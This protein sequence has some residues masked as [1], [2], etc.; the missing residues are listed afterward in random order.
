CEGLGR[1]YEQIFAKL[2]L[3]VQERFFAALD[4]GCNANTLSRLAAQY[5]RVRGGIGFNK[6][7]AEY[8]AF[9]TDPYSHTPGHAGARQPG[10]TGQVKEEILTRFGELGVRVSDGAAR[11]EPRLLRRQEFL[12]TP[13]K[14]RMLDVNN[15]WQI[16]ETPEHGLAFSLCQVPITYRLDVRSAAD[17]AITIRMSDGRQQQLEGLALPREIS[18]SIFKRDGTIAQLDVA[19]GQQWLM[20]QGAG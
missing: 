2:L 7:P 12:A 8:G 6:S 4:S 20:Q 17:A 11:F 19:F 18:Q 9:P 16:V 10:M 14:R 3:A 5:Y 15:R 1:I 13:G